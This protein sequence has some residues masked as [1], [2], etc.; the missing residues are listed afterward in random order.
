MSFEDLE[1]H[2]AERERT[3]LEAAPK[4]GRLGTAMGYSQREIEESCGMIGLNEAQTRNV[5]MRLNARWN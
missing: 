1:R 4:V 5:M 2:G 3:M